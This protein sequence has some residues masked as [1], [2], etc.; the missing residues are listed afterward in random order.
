MIDYF[1]STFLVLICI[2]SAQGKSALEWRARK[3]PPLRDII[4]VTHVK[5]LYYLTDEDYLNE[6]AEQIL[7]LGSRV[8][9]VWFHKPQESYPYNSDWPRMDTLVEI[10]KSPYFAELFDKPFTTYIMM[11]FSMG[12]P[13]AYWRKGITEQQKADEKR[14]FY[15]LTKYLLTAYKETGKKFVLQHWEG[16]WLIRG[17]FDKKVDPDPVAIKGMNGFCALYLRVLS[18]P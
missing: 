18:V 13:A 5:G 1:F 9:K 7:A 6:G 17:G 3:K 2:G 14:Q 12:R 4:G 16:D 15:E 11:C 10:A 8:I